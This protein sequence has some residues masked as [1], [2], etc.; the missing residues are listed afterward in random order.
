VTPDGRGVVRSYKVPADA[1]V[2][3][4]EGVEGDRLYTLDAVRE[5]RRG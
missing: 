2:V 4:L 3:R 1:V 5:Q